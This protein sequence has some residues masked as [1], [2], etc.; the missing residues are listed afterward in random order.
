M[1]EVGCGTGYVLQALVHECGLIATGSELHAEGLYHARGRLPEADF[2]E[3]D[4]RAMTYEG[5]FDLVAAFDVLEHI[6][7][8]TGVL[9]G[10]YR[11]ARPGGVLL[12]TVPQHPWL[13]SRADHDA[14]HVR[15]Y[16]RGQ[17]VSRVTQAGFTPLRT[18]S[19]VTLLLPL[20]VLSRWGERLERRAEHDT[21]DD[22]VP[23][24]LINSMF[25]RVLAL[26]R[27]AIRR[28][29]TYQQAVHSCS[30][31]RSR[32]RSV[33]YP[34]RRRPAERPADQADRVCGR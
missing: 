19:F 1:L 2:V 30:L 26:E 32:R 28:E 14:R 16:T 10:L 11:A 5:A 33:Q 17:L 31:Q 22:L 3:L 21:L 25:E 12:V 18:T 9:R 4:A 27:F 20:M 29:S 23:P 6:D 13:W 34:S 8:D 24:T 15:R 7:D